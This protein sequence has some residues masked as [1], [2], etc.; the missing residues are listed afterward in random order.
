MIPSSSIS[1]R[2]LWIFVCILALLALLGTVSMGI[3]PKRPFKFSRWSS[4][5]HAAL[6]PDKPRRT[7]LRVGDI[8]TEGLGVR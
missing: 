3:G 2:F 6:A 5:Q 1:R 4:Q 7:Y 8:G